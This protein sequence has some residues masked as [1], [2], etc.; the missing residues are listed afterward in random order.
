MRTRTK[1]PRPQRDAF[2]INPSARQRIKWLFEPIRVELHDPNKC[3][4]Y[5][6]YVQDN[7]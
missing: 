3:H 5:S 4:F 7:Y 2:N 1:V 6:N